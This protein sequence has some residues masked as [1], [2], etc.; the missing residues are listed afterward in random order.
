MKIAFVTGAAGFT[1]YSL[2]C[3]LLEHGYFVNAIVR[4]NSGN[5]TRLLGINRVNIIE[6][7]ID[8]IIQI[9]KSNKVMYRDSPEKFFFHL[10]WQGD[11]YNFVSQ[12]KNIGMT[13]N[14]LEAAAKLSCR[15]FISVGSQAEYGVVNGCIHET[16]MPNPFCDYGAAKVSACYLTK[17]RSRELGIEWIWGRIFSL[18]GQ[19]EPNT[20]MLPN[21]VCKMRDCTDVYLSS[22]RQYWDYLN[23]G[24]AAEALIALAE[25]GISGEIYNIANGNYRPLREYVNIVQKQYS[26]TGR[27]FYGGDPEPFV[28]LKPSIDKIMNDTGWKPR[29]P[30]EKGIEVYREMG[31]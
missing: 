10:A 25:N 27:I 30:F 2:V 19:Y 16:L 7:D 17:R 21:I 11:R 5:N 4:P 22:C 9:V 3:H 28:T 26:S 8:D 12:V 24:D 15:R 13:I 31:I 23:V 20:R 18:Y 1:G 6:C 29:V 14:A